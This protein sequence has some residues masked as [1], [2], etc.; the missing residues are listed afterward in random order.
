MGVL[1]LIGIDSRGDLYVGEVAY[2]AYINRLV[3][4]QE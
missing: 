1:G 2:S 4:E 3:P